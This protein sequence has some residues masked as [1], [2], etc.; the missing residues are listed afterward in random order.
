MLDPLLLL[1]EEKLVEDVIEQSLEIIEML[2]VI[3]GV[4]E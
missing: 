3:E 2:F 4:D 1:V